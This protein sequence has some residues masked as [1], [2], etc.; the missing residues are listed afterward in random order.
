M[1]FSKIIDVI[2]CVHDKYWFQ[3][4][5]IGIISPRRELMVIKCDESSCRQI[6]YL[7]AESWVFFCQRDPACH[8]RHQAEYL[9]FSL[10][11]L[12]AAW[13][14]ISGRMRRREIAQLFCLRIVLPRWLLRVSLSLLRFSFSSSNSLVWNFSL[15]KERAL[16]WIISSS[17]S[18]FVDSTIAMHY[19]RRRNVFQRLDSIT[20]QYYDYTVN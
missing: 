17:L 7:V 3:S 12:C 6:Y 9:A 11:T 16:S 1:Q 18:P 15:G 5:Y 10:L 2:V 4:P 13:H 8:I 14:C 19:V 20:G